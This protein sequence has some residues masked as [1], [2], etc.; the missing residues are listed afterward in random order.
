[1]GI[2]RATIKS[3]A[4]V[5]MS[6]S[7]PNPMWI[8]LLFLLVSAGLPSLVFYATGIGEI[9]SSHGPYYSYDWSYQIS[10]SYS[11][12]SP[13]IR[14]FVFVISAL[15]SVLSFGHTIYCLRVARNQDVSFRTIFS[16]FTRCIKVIGLYLFIMLF[17]W[18]WALLFVI[19]GIIASYRYRMA[20][21][22]LI[23]NPDLSIR[24]CV[25]ISKQ[26]MMGRKGELFLLDL[27]FIGWGLLCAIPLLGWILTLWVIPYEGVTIANYYEALKGLPDA[28]SYYNNNPSQGPQTPPYEF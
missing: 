13:F 2:D 15:I 5:S 7:Y 25:N 8:S 18:L 23:D 9:V 4:K 26:M 24:E 22:I 28:A 12:W 11:A 17:T 6:G 21:Y 16:G 27:S 20:P 1:M 10:S 19:P 14:L 3:N